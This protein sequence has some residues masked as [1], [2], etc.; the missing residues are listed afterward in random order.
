[1]CFLTALIITRTKPPLPVSSSSFFS[2]HCFTSPPTPAP[3]PSEGQLNVSASCL[4]TEQCGM[5]ETYPFLP[6]FV[7]AGESPHLSS[8]FSL[9]TDFF[10]FANPAS[11]HSKPFLFLL[12]QL[13][14]QLLLLRLLSMHQTQALCGNF[15]VLLFRNLGGEFP[16]QIQENFIAHHSWT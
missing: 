10:S 12:I 3:P 16:F 1:M 4:V 9:L 5:R 13:I 7:L 6:S 15:Q 11:C 8:Y 14:I 2:P